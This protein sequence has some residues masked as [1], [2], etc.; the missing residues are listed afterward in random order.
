MKH[1]ITLCMIVKDEEERLEACLA[2]AADYVDEMIVVDTGSTDGTM[3]IARG[4]GA[5]VVQTVWENDFAKARNAG[6]EL[7]TS[8]WVLCLDA[9]ERLAP[10]SA[11]YL[12]FL[13][14]QEDAHGY[15]VQI[16]SF[17]GDASYG[18]YMTDEACRLFRSDPRIRFTRPIHEQVVPSLL[19]VPGARLLRSKLTVLHDGYLDAVIAG[20]NKNE[21]NSTIL[22][23]V[24]QCHPNDPEYRYAYGTELFQQ[25]RYDEALQLFLPLLET[26][27]ECGSTVTEFDI[28]SGLGTGSGFDIGSA[29]IPDLMLKSAYALHQTGRTKAAIELLRQGVDR[30]HAHSDLLE[31]LAGLYLKLRLPAEAI[32]LLER[33]L[34]AGS[35]SG[36]YSTLSG[37]G[38]YRSL[39]LTGLAYEGIWRFGEAVDRYSEALSVRPNFAPPW[40]RLPLLAMIT[41]HEEKLESLLAELGTLVPPDVWVSVIHETIYCRKDDLAARI[42][43]FTPDPIRKQFYPLWEGIVLAREGAD[44]ALRHMEL[45]DSCA[46]AEWYLWAIRAKMEPEAVVEHLT[47]PGFQ[48]DPMSEVLYRRCQ[49]ILLQIGAWEA[50]LR[51]MDRSPPDIAAPELPIH[52]YYAYL[53]APEEA[54]AALLGMANRSREKLAAR[55]GLALGALAFHADMLHQSLDWFHYACQSE[56]YRVESSAA[57]ACVSQAM[58]RRMLP[59]NLTGVIEGSDEARCGMAIRSLLILPG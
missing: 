41:G 30:Y 47:P 59:A 13:T 51:L 3:R 24:L 44:M 54:I 48:G 27:G 8:S 39:H 18:E 37:S 31:L 6:L 5:R 12:S 36:I 56:P 43:D 11:D 2:S 33:A 21:R 35:G 50:A 15:Y 52:R 46:E 22:Q 32:P 49:D 58:V 23:T 25:Q 29:R 53:A 10:P 17:I 1:D 45:L 4:F 55:D 38:S 19:A 28:D 42:W 14:G 26:D 7:V 20:K 9:D 40:S 57:L 16:N 34:A